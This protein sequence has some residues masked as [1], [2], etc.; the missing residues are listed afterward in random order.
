MEEQNKSLKIG[1]FLRGLIYLGYSIFVITMLLIQFIAVSLLVSIIIPTIVQFF[2]GIFPRVIYN[3][4]KFLLF[5]LLQIF[6]NFPVFS[7]IVCVILQIVESFFK[8][9]EDNL[10]F[11]KYVGFIIEN[12]ENR[13]QNNNNQGKF[14]CFFIFLC[15]L[16]DIGLVVEFLHGGIV[17]SGIVICIIGFAPVVIGICKVFFVSYCVLFGKVT[18]EN[19]EKPIS[20]SMVEEKNE[21]DDKN[22]NALYSNSLFDPAN[23]SNQNQWVSFVTDSET[24]SFIK[25]GFHGW[26]LFVAVLVAFAVLPTLF[27]LWDLWGMIQYCRIWVPIYFVMNIGAIP[28]FLY[29]NIFTSFIPKEKFVEKEKV[30]LSIKIVKIVFISL[31][32]V[33][34]LFSI[35]ILLWRPFP[36]PELK[37]INQS[38]T[39]YTLKKSLPSFCYHKTPGGLSL[40]Q[41]AGLQ[42]LS[43]LFSYQNGAPRL[44]PGSEDVLNNSM[45]YFF[46]QDDDLLDQISIKPIGNKYI[47]LFITLQSQ[48]DTEFVVLNTINSLYSWALYLETYVKV[49]IPT[50]LESVVPF[51]SVIDSLLS[52][53]V[54]Y[55]S[56]FGTLTTTRLPHSD[57]MSMTLFHSLNH[58][59]TNVIIGHTIGGYI[60]KYI[61]NPRSYHSISF[62][63]FPSVMSL[64][65][66]LLSM[67]EHFSEFSPP[68]PNM[69]LN[70]YTDNIFG[71]P[72]NDVNTNIK[73]PNFKLP[74]QIPNV[75][76]SFCTISALCSNSDTI[77]SYCAQVLSINKNNG[78][79]LYRSMIDYA[80][81]FNK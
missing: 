20:S 48:P 14:V 31:F 71:M 70:F 30:F 62:E 33:F 73:L 15:V 80:Q 42:T 54:L 72:D 66:L 65:K 63:G 40:V 9:L 77:A 11:G 36:V 57:E 43:T 4:W 61:S 35:L 37:Y 46:G 13:S 38:I 19:H 39:N 75:Y 23:L 69:I 45:K 22:G 50:L 64:N 32:V 74:F 67:E 59:K 6:V 24:N 47:T 79:E 3:G 81:R 10:S 7:I 55:L 25:K 1:K 29:G 2:I 68:N 28:F 21:K 8:S 17:Y 78:S 52:F 27:E 5:I 51:F 60:A 49:F 56:Y 26:N 16:L 44:I 53:Q 18:N 76:E 41:I 58:S 34:A 12:L